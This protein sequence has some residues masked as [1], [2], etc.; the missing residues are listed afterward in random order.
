MDATA[1]LS[2][3]ERTIRSK[4]HLLMRLRVVRQSYDALRPFG[5]TA[6]ERARFHFGQL[7]PCWSRVIE[8]QRVIGLEAAHFTPREQFEKI[9]VVSAF[10]DREFASAENTMLDV[11][12]SWQ[13]YKTHL[14]KLSYGVNPFE[15][16]E[17]CGRCYRAIQ[18]LNGLVA[19]PA[20]VIPGPKLDP[21]G[22]PD[23]TGARLRMREW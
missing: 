7:E 22:L 14:Q 20:D 16:G 5:Q 17:L 15:F 21:G 19:S 3:G 2:P 18:A 9:F 10:A 13:T 8:F 23:L 11:F 1:I 6:V 12:G 4:L